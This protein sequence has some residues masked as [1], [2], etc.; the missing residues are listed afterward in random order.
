MH[1]FAGVRRE[2]CTV[3]TDDRS[4]SFAL[5]MCLCNTPVLRV[6]SVINIELKAD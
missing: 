4:E 5:H 3:Y 1:T 6:F 2:S